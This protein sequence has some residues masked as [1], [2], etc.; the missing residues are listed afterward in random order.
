MDSRVDPRD[1][2]HG[3]P[4]TERKVVHQR[5]QPKGR[6]YQI[7]QE[8]SKAILDGDQEVAVQLARMHHAGSD[9][10]LAGNR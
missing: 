3:P 5:Q 9:R 2:W 8:L 10:E 7:A 6:W 4:K 1:E